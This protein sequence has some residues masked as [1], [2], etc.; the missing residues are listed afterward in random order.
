M[1]KLNGTKQQ[2]NITKHET[3]MI[4]EKYYVYVSRLDENPV[5]M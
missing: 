2:R 5:N 3:G 4:H 1:S